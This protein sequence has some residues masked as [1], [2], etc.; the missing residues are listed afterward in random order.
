[1]TSANSNPNPNPNPNPTNAVPVDN[2][3]SVVALNTQNST[4]LT[5]SNY[6]IWK[7]QMTAL[8]IGYDLFRFVDGSSACP[9]P[10][11]RNYNNWRRQDQ[12]ILHAIITS[13]DQQVISL[14]GN[15]KNSK[16]A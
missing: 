9:S 2:S 10:T 14:L 6:P 11:H 5:G 8:L 13:V 12:L 3:G 4:K 1:M 15:A 16:D 7:V